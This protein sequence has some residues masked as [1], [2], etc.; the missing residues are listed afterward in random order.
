[1]VFRLS[2]PCR[3][4]GFT[5]IELLV[6][7]GIIGILSAVMLST[8]GGASESAQAAKCMTNMRTLSSAVYTAASANDDGHFPAANSFEYFDSA[9]IAYRSGWVG[10]QNKVSD[11][12]KNRNRKTESLV[13]YAWTSF[14]TYP[15]GNRGESDKS[16]VALSTG[17]IWQYV[18]RTAEVYTCPVHVKACRAQNLI[19]SWSYVMN[20]LFGYDDK[21]GKT[22]N[23]QGKSLSGITSVNGVPLGADKVLLFAE[24]PFKDWSKERTVDIQN[25]VRLEGSDA[26]FDSALQYDDGKWSKPESIGFN[27]KSGKRVLAHVAYADGHVAKLF[28]PKNASEGDVRNLTVWLCQGDEISFDGSR[29]ERVSQADSRTKK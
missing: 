11:A 4:G 8:F 17:A 26:E 19:P 23:W 29:Y 24:L 15:Q 20:S 22:T 6:V 16:K 14:A 25:G 1:M 13:Q 27:H 10:W 3:R 12:Y 2:Q 28:L 21:K 9:S 18:G 7:I 5:L